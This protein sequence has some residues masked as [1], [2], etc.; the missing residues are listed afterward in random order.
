M[1]CRENN[2]G[3]LLDEIFYSGKCRTI[4]SICE[5]KNL[6]GLDENHC[7]NTSVNLKV[8]INDV[9]TRTLSAE[10]FF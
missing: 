9:I 2:A 3:N 6:H 8:H 7:L 1:K 4:E 5:L 10:E